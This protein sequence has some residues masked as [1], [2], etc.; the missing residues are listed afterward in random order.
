VFVVLVAT[1]LGFLFR[2]NFDI[3]EIIKFHPVGGLILT[4]LTGLVSTFATRSYAGIVRYTGVEDGIR[5]M[6]ASLLSLG[7]AGSFNLLYF[8]N[9]GRNLIPYS[10]LFIS[11][12]Q[13]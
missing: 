6:Y 13:R 11:F 9:E 3:N 2:F 12:L 1:S 4:V 5:I 8:Y 7:L 10:V